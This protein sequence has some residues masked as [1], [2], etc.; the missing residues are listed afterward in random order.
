MLSHIV[1]SHPIF[2]PLDFHKKN[3]VKLKVPYKI[4]TPP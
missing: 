3:S 1:I 4:Y 2:L